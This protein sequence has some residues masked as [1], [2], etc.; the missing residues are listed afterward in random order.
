C[1]L[2]NLHG[3]ALV[4]VQGHLGILL[5]KAAD[6][7]RQGVAGL[8]VGGG[9]A[10]GAT[11]LVGK[12]L[13]DLLDALALAQDLSSGADDSLAGR[14]NAGQML[15]AAGEY[16]DAQLVFEQPNLLA[17]A[18][19]GGEQ[20]LRRGRDVEVM[21]LH[22]PNVTQLLQLHRNPSRTDDMPE[23]HL[24]TASLRKAGSL[25]HFYREALRLLP[26]ARTDR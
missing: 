26:T 13:R 21:M 6:H 8:G 19:L 1:H 5:D 12:L 23:R 18:R 10:Q 24:I 4:H 15:A 2:G 14:R 16:L 3:R 17:D 9:D 7:R 11:L 25:D 22:L 20:A